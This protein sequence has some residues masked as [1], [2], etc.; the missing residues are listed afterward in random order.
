M[1]T[2]TAAANNPTL[3]APLN[4]NHP[5]TQADWQQC[6]NQ[7]QTWQNV[8]GIIVPP[9]QQTDAERTAGVT[10]TNYA[11]P[12]MNVRRYGAT[13]N[14]T[15]DDTAAIQAAINV[16]QAQ[17]TAGS[18]IIP[19]GNYLVSSPLNITANFLRIVGDS[20]NCTSI[21]CN[22]SGMSTVFNVNN[23]GHAIFGVQF[24]DLAINIAA[25]LGSPP[26]GITFKDASECYVDRFFC[27][28]HTHGIVMNGVDIMRVMDYESG[29]VSSTGIYITISGT[30]VFTSNDMVWLQNLNLFHNSTA[31]VWIAQQGNDIQIHDS[32]MEQHPAAVLFKPD[33]A[34][35]TIC[36]KVVLDNVTSWNNT[37]GA[38]NNTSLVVMTALSGAGTFLQ[39]T[40]VVIDNCKS[41]QNTSPTYHLQIQLNGN[42]NA[43]TAF[44]KIQVRDGEFYGPATAVLSS[45]AAAGVTTCNGD[46]RGQITALSGY[47]TGTPV[48]L[49]N[50]GSV[51]PTGGVVGWGTEEIGTAAITDGS[52]AG[53][54]FSNVYTN[55]TR[56]GTKAY[57]SVRL[58]YPATA[59]G[60]SAALTGLPFTSI[61]ALG[62]VFGSPLLAGPV[63]AAGTLALVSNG[64]NSVSFVAINGA[65]VT[66]ATLT[67]ATIAFTVEFESQ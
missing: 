45:N 47:Q 9:M 64:G 42:S 50:G 31:G 55:C 43:N 21:T 17:S 59:S 29:G 10:P 3:P 35:S 32:Y 2:T 58:T 38:F 18:V 14:G 60:A 11:Y 1:T 34:V 8:L 24:Q 12:P 40:N 20:R 16:A 48:P 51:T 6:L 37:G 4:Q 63:G 19:G 13:G 5:K 52:G 33:T 65:P 61:S 26:N 36:D 54:T 15:T 7:L 25:S 57:C 30:S 27:A 66:N 56:K 22:T 67:G 41:F 49:R 23:P 28:N 39:V 44:I 62:P 46:F 53:L